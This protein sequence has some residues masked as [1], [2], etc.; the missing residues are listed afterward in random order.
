[1]SPDLAE[2]YAYV[3]FGDADRARLRALHPVLAPC[4]PELADRFYEAVRAAP[5]AA[6]VLAD[7]AQDPAQAERLRSALIDWMS[8]G[9]LGPHDER[10]YAQRSRIGRRHVALGLLPHYMFGAMNVLR[11]AYHDR[12]L[13]LAPPAEAVAAMRAVDR[14]LDIELAIMTRHYQLD[15]EARRV[16]HERRSVADRLT[17]MQTLSAGLAH[18]VRNPLNAAQLQLELL[19]RRLRRDG[20]GPRFTDPI[21]Q[22]QQEL[23][24][25]TALL[26]DFLAFARPPELLVGEHDV[27]AVVRQAVE[28][29]RSLAERRGASLELASAEPLIAAVDGPKLHQVVANLVRNAIEAG[30]GHVWVAVVPGDERFVIRVA[31]DGPGIPE[32]VRARMYEPFFTTKESGTGLGM[33]IVHS[34]VALHGGTIDL[35]SGP[36]GTRFDIAIP[37]RH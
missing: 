25:L 17:A 20:H 18:E 8:T 28:P 9:L 35:D 21:G 1:V 27:A 16:A 19:E 23:T 2:L 12:I 5:G 30:G 10:F 24:R 32:D 4:F 14:L 6:A 29:E 26:D 37:R 22:A 34:L 36:S 33:S 7:P 31:D 11:S 13:A 3:G 15:S